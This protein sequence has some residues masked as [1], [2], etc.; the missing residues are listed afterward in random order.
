M[1]AFVEADPEWRE[2]EK[3]IGSGR[4]S[5]MLGMAWDTWHEGGGKERVR[6]MVERGVVRRKASD[7]L[8]SL[9]E[10]STLAIGEEEADDQVRVVS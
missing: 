3:E 7:L 6:A 4:H 2:R 1:P 8:R 10:V 9:G 5:A